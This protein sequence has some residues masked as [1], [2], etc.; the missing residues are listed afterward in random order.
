MMR[1]RVVAGVVMAGA[2]IAA[3]GCGSGGKSTTAAAESTPTPTGQ[4]SE[5][6]NPGRRANWPTYHANLAR[7]G[8]DTTSPGLSGFHRT[9]TQQFDGQVYAEPLAVGN[10]VYVATENNTVY[11]LNASNGHIAWKRHLGTP[12]DGSTRTCGNIEAVTGITGNPAISHGT[13]YVCA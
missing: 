4:A 12:V 9:W 6:K 7:T 8:V 5:A 10:R 3:I 11:A 1:T 13:N 2:L